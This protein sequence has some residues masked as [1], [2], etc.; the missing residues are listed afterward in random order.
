MSNK[1]SVGAVTI[2]LL[3]L[4]I[5]YFAPKTI[6]QPE[7]VREV[8]REIVQSNDDEGLGAIPG[9]E[10]NGREFTIGGSKIV[11]ER[12]PF[13]NGTSTICAIKKPN[14]ATSTLLW[15]SVNGKSNFATSAKGVYIDLAIIAEDSATSSAFATTSG[16]VLGTP[17]IAEP[18]RT[19]VTASST[20]G[21]AADINFNRNDFAYAVAV[22]SNQAWGDYSKWQPVGQCSAAWLVME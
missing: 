8:I 9:T 18:S 10:V 2:A 13:I 17:F 4:G 20:A 12:Q 3:A 15:F 11:Y 19:T 7:T 21:A 5:S 16:N 6:V 14:N 1:L 22:A